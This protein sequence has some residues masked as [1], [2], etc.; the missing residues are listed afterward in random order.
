M[1]VVK[2]G[3]R[4][5]LTVKPGTIVFA[6]ERRGWQYLNRD[7]AIKLRVRSLVDDSHSSAT[8]LGGDFVM[9]Q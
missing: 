2:L 3:S 5:S 6:G 9:R 4:L 7:V 1:C 8:E